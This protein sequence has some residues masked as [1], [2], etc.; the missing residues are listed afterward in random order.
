[1]SCQWS[2][3]PQKKELSNNVVTPYSPINLTATP[4]SPF[5]IDLLWYD[6]SNNNNKE[7]SKIERSANGIDFVEI[8]KV[9]PSKNSYSDKGLDGGKTYWYRV[10]AYKDT[11]NHIY[12]NISSATLPW[13][14]TFGSREDDVVYSMQ[15]TSDG[16]YIVVGNTSFG[17]GKTDILVLKLY[18][19]GKI[20]WQKTY[21]GKKDDGAC[22]IQQTADGGYIVMG[23]SS[24][25]DE[26]SGFWMLKLNHDGGIAWQKSYPN[27][28]KG[29]I[30]SIQQTKGGGYIAVGR[31]M[32][33]HGEHGGVI[34]T[35]GYD[36]WVVKFD[37]EGRVEWQKMYGGEKWDEA[38][39][40]Q[41][42]SDGGYIVA[43]YLN[44]FDFLILRL[45]SDGKIA[46]KKIY[47]RTGKPSAIQQT[48]DGGY[49]V[50]GFISFGSG[51]EYD[52]WVLKLN[53]EGVTLWQKAYG[54][55]KKDVADFIQQ[56]SDGGYIVACTTNSFGAGGHDFW[57][58]KLD[59]NGNIDWQK[60][61]GGAGNDS[62][63]SI[64]QTNDGGY[65]VAG[66]TESFGAGERDIWI[67][68]LS[69]YG[70]VRSPESAIRTTNTSAAVTE[71][72]V[73]DTTIPLMVVDTRLISKDASGMVRDTN[74]FVHQQ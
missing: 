34:G 2:P 57:V 43:G 5:Q 21:G 25:F 62:A 61:Y 35:G 8:E 17:I 41:Q 65:I 16:G 54:G 23:D 10:R 70:T 55:P 72:S 51:K 1:M 39:A 58:L 59:H 42:T 11:G 52:V 36:L 47:E 73:K 37:T 31:R 32:S 3:T 67:L 19:D 13:V 63:S 29:N 12:S 26:D 45:N 68:K 40:V 15:Q 33:V 6:T 14:K 30:V 66:V 71:T 46:W 4:V 60:S 53:S 9:P 56:T 22:C 69:T 74:L 49:I 64:Q 24:S 18:P 50:A 44:S 7:D 28:I 48:A 20:A 38:S 27:A